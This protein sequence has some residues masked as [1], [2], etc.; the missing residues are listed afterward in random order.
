MESLNVSQ[1]D[2]EKANKIIKEKI[3]ESNKIKSIYQNNLTSECWL[4]QI[5]GLNNCNTCE[6]KGKRDCGGKQIRKTGK[7]NLGLN[8][9]IS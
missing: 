7:N 4:V 2:I 6:Q 5:Y 9:P 1:K 3:V 8:V